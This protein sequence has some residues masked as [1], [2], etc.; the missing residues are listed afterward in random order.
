[1][2]VH[3]IPPAVN[4]GGAAAPRAASSPRR[5]C[6]D[7]GSEL[8]RGSAGE[9]PVCVEC[10][11]PFAPPDLDVGGIRFAPCP[12]APP[13]VEPVPPADAF[14][15]VDPAEH[16]EWATRVGIAAGRRHHLPPGSPDLQDVIQ[17]AL[18]TMCEQ[19][20]RFTPDRIIRSG[21]DAPTAFQRWS[22]ATVAGRCADEVTR[23][24]GGGTV[25][26]CAG[27]RPVV[28]SLEA[29]C[30]EHGVGR[31]LLRLR[32]HADFRT[33]YVGR[34]PAAAKYHR[35][36]KE[37]KERFRNKVAADPKWSGP[38]YM[39]R[40]TNGHVLAMAVTRDPATGDRL[41]PSKTFRL[42]TEARKWL[43][44]VMGTRK[45]AKFKITGPGHASAPAGGG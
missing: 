9:N 29:L 44:E 45:H 34:G 16:I 4:R 30:G 38:G 23:L 17:V 22:Y 35:V 18:L 5:V 24:R 13:A 40:T 36:P 26:R 41:R 11:V 28:G 15:P 14:R 1:M 39:Y 12:D 10:P 21:D 19:A 31:T 27:D 7:C 6:P 43:R 3:A 25:K 33:P 8:V 42:V 32:P 20:R 37:P 2:K